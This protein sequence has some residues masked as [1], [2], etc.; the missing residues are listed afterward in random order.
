MRLRANVG[1]ED[2]LKNKLLIHK[3]LLRYSAKFE[4]SKFLFTEDGDLEVTTCLNLNIC[5]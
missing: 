2:V 3:N 1:P 5:G 4:R